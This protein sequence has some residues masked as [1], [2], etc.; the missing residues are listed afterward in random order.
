MKGIDIKKA[1]LA[2]GHNVSE[3]AAGIGKSQQNL[4]AALASEDV[5]TGLVESIASFLNIPI[6]S[7]YGEGTTATA[8]GTNNTSV[9]GNGNTLNDRALIDEIAAQRR[10]TEQALTQNDRLI[11]IIE[12]LTTK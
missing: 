5:K 4:S 3:V 11:G 2:S 8:S 12:E 1:I 10:M 9:A 6:S 7:L